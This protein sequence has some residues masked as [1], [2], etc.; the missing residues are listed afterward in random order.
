MKIS[1]KISLAIII[2][3]TLHVLG[4]SAYIFDIIPIECQK[5]YFYNLDRIYIITMMGLFWLISTKKLVRLTLATSFFI[6]LTTTVIVNI[7]YFVNLT[8]ET[9]NK[10]WIIFMAVSIITCLITLLYVSNRQIHK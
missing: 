4:F 5:Y 1:Y 10:I 2:T 7:K 6:H 3:A 9:N 8:V